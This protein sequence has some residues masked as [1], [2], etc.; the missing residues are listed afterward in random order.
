MFPRMR[1]NK[2]SHKT[3]LYDVI[4]ARLPPKLLQCP[5]TL[6]YEEGSVWRL[7]R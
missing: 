3:T 1:E 4:G 6:R 5:W 7:L 2:L